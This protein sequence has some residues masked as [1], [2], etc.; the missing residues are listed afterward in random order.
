[1]RRVAEQIAANG[2]VQHARLGISVQEVN[3]LLAESF[4]LPRPM[5]ALVS[6]VDP[7]TAAA[8]AGLQS[9]DIVLALNGKTIEAAADLSETMGAAKP[10]DSLQIKV[11]RDGRA[12]DLRARL[13]TAAPAQ[14]PATVA[15]AAPNGGR[16]GLSL[17]ALHPDEKGEDGLLSGLLVEKANEAAT[18]AGVQ[19]GDVLLSVG[20]KP[21]TAVEQ[22]SKLLPA[23]QGITALLVQRGGSKLYLAL[24]LG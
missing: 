16:L 15:D 3:Q 10:G 22:I 1:V 2:A 4:K 18:R 6:S 5:G 17:R 12:K 7:G 13:E 21:V 20:G 9:G 19:V 11:W 8:T 14:P 24:R 23:G